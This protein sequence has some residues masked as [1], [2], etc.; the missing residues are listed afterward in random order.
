MSAAVDTVQLNCD[1]TAR[2]SK[3]IITSGLIIIT[4]LVGGFGLWAGLAP[5]ASGVMASGVVVAEGTRSTVQHLEGG[6]VKEILIKE[7]D[8]VVAGQVLLRLD[9]VQT[10]SRLGSLQ[11]E[12][13]GLQAREAR[14]VAEQS[15]QSDISFS[16]D[17][18]ARNKNQ[19]VFDI[20]AGETTLFEERRNAL[21]TSLK[22]IGQQ[23]TLYERHIVGSMAQIKSSTIQRSISQEELEGL[24]TL[25]AKGYVAKTRLL[26]LQRENA[27]LEGVIGEKQSQVSQAEIK[28]LES[29][30]EEAQV[31]TDFR[32]E[33][34]SELREVQGNLFKLE[35]QILAT[36]DTLKRL[37]IKAP[38]D[39]VVIDLQFHAINTV[40]LSGAPVLDIVPNGDALIIDARIKPIDIDNVLVGAEAE[41]RFP[42]FRQRTT[43]SVFGIV[44]VVSADTLLDPAT[45][46]PYYTARIMVTE[47]ERQR[48]PNRSIVSGMPADV[49]V[50]SEDRTLIEYMTEPLTDVLARSF[51]E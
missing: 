3:R 22:M 21:D 37:E 34:I 16:A 48:I 44:Q 35:E 20:M 51:K 18:L 2:S 49:T 8:A 24:E 45:N 1:Q 7:G 9:E 10:K 29:S 13:D 17:L 50:R 11:A 41:V 30:V 28:V 32:K 39:G 12:F 31:K 38:R 19:R 46:E 36:K 23:K 33:V 43:P 15:G 40:V 5:L 47:Q 27:R 26:K 6:I 14:L 42:A 4:V 25:F